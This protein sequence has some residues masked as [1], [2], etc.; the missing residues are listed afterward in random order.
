MRDTGGVDK[1]R[2]FLRVKLKVTAWILWLKRKS[3]VSPVEYGS[4]DPRFETGLK[5]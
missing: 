5:M 4:L 3:Q 1:L 2:R